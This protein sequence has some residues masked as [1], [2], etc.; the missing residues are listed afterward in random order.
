MSKMCSLLLGS[1]D[2]AGEASHVYKGRETQEPRCS[3]W[4]LN[5]TRILTLVLS[6]TCYVPLSRS[7]SHSGLG[8]QQE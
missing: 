8:T 3:T 2:T 5:T 7:L 1:L 4:A 6:I